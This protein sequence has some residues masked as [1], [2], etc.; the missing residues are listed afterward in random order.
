MKGIWLVFAFGGLAVIGGAIRAADE[1]P[2]LPPIYDEKADAE[3]QIRS[4]LAAARKEQ[5]RVLIQWGA[6][7]CSWCHRLH[8][9]FSKD[10]E[11]A[12]TL[13]ANYEYVLVDIGR[14]DK[15]IALAARY[16][17][18]PEKTGIPLVTILEADGKVV[19]NQDMEPYEKPKGGEKGY[20]QAK[21]AEF[22]E[23]Y[24]SHR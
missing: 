24:K 2:K 13:K 6:N 19:V 15:N 21:L 18:H 8:K 4:A 3:A 16:G 23:K 1:K 10:M 5:R 22:L 14:R 20:Q 9:D 17:A 7:W 12:R 11:L